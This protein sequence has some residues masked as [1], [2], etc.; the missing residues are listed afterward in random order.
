MDGVLTSTSKET[1]EV[2]SQAELINRA[3]AGDDV[4]DEFEKDKEEVLN[5]EVPKPEKPV[6]VPGWGDWTNI[7]KKRGISKQMV[8]KHEAEKKEWEQ[9]LKT[10]KDARLKHVIISEKVDKKVSSVP[11]SSFSFL[12][13][14]FNL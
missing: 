9:G 12:I 7:Q 8:Q 2:P 3:F 5:Q 10:R 13:K 6:L 4:L 11:H 1:F 14:P